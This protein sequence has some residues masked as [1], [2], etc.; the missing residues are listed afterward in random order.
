MFANINVNY[1]G[2]AA[3]EIILNIGEHTLYWLFAIFHQ[4]AAIKS[5]RKKSKSEIAL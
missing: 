5:N 2:K 3:F 4:L 1:D